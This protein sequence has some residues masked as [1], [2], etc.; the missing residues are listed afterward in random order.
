VPCRLAL[1]HGWAWA[2]EAAPVTIAANASIE[3]I[4]VFMDCAF[5]SWPIVGVVRECGIRSWGNSMQR[6]SRVSK[7][8]VT[9]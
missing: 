6:E 2:G 7:M 9:R 8:L 3:R 5:L 1:E 4:F